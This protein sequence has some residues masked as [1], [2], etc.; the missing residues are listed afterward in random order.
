MNDTALMRRALGLAAKGADGAAPNP[1]VGCVVSRDGRVIAEG[2]HAAPDEPHAEA[3]ALAQLGGYQE[4]AG[5]DV[6]VTLEPCAHEGRTPS[7]AAALLRA[8]PRRVVAAMADPDPRVSGAGCALLREAGIRVELGLLAEEA[9]WLNRGF[10]SRLTRGRP[11]LRV[12]TACTLDGRCALP[13]GS[14]KWITSEQARGDAHALRAA[15]CAMVTGI[16]TALAD[17]PR[18]TARLGPVRRQPLRV[19]VDSTLRC[20]AKLKMFAG[21][22]VVATASNADPSA[23]GEQVEIVSLPDG[24]GKVDLEA[25]AIWL[26]VARKCNF[27]TFEAGP[28]LTGGLIETGLADELVCY[29]APK[30]FGCG[31][32]SVAFAGTGSM[33]HAPQFSVREAARLGPDVKITLTAA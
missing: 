17:D 14:S 4:A 11:W 29:V 8:R 10:L 26:A 1:M 5:T 30:I 18:L 3:A 22:A 16:G 9:A 32:A 31:L 33:E 13:D 15:S 27:V 28:K 25:L 21:G 24:K 20:S 19:L 23:L 12:K 6:F 7:C 2:F